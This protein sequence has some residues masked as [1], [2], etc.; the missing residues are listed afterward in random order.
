FRDNNRDKLLQLVAKHRVDMLIMDEVHLAK[1][2]ADG[3]ITSADR[4]EV[5]QRRST[6]LDVRTA[7]QDINPEVAVLGMSATPV[8]NDLMEPV[9][10]LTLIEGRDYSEVKT[11]N[12]AHNA[13]VI[14]SH[15]TRIGV[16]YMP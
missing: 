3:S 4:R 2:R 8:I 10:L 9:S 6:L 15:I 16:R 14:H 13:L 12:T 7:A 1:S 11:K 5:S